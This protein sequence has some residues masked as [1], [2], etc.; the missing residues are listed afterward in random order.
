MR[1]PRY[2]PVQIELVDACVAGEPLQV[3]LRALPGLA[4]KEA[5]KITVD[6]QQLDGSAKPLHREVATAP[7]EGGARLTFEA[8]PAGGY[9]A[10]AK[11]GNMTTVRRDFACEVGGQEWADPRPAPEHMRAIA[12]A[13][14][15][16]SV[17]ARDVKRIPFPEAKVLTT[18]RRELPLLPA[19]AWAL[20]AATLAGAHWIVRRRTGLL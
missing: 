12:E 16:V 8:M 11:F 10:R 3:E 7:G 5:S 15:G 19:W 17:S 9:S 4:P 6:V 2:E 20:A 18:M 13:A 14:H 1:D